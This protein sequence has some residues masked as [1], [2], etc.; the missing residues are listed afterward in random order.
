MEAFLPQVGVQSS[1][2]FLQKKTQEE[3]L[4]R[5]IRYDIFMA[6]AER[7]GKDRR[8]ATVFERDED[9]GEILVDQTTEYL[10]QNKDGEKIL[11]MRREKVKKIDDDLPK[12]VSAYKKFIKD[13]NF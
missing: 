12:I 2:L 1:L 10:I 4:A 9:G 3:V 7:L 8:G 5:D 6:I 11:K 13:E